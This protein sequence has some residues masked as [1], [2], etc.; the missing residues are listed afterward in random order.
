MRQGREGS[1]LQGWE[2]SSCWEAPPRNFLEV[3]FVRLL[4]HRHR[5]LTAPGAD[6]DRRNFLRVQTLIN[7]ALSPGEALDSEGIH[8]LTRQVICISRFLREGAHG[9]PGV[10]VLEAV[11]RC[12]GISN[13][14]YNVA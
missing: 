7:R 10:G 3:G 6:G 9:G 12:L 4:I 1:L 5:M 2:V 13:Y 14:Q 11:D 8:I